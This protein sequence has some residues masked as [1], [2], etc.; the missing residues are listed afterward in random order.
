MKHRIFQSIFLL[1]ILVLLGGWFWDNKSENYVNECPE[2][3]GAMATV[4]SLHIGREGVPMAVDLDAWYAFE[5]AVGAADIEA[6]N[7]LYRR[8]KVADILPDGRV[9][10]YICRGILV[11]IRDIDNRSPLKYGWMLRSALEIE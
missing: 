9:K 3:K 7:D 10:I 6:I 4:K 8:D 2:L 11:Y 5:G 1:I